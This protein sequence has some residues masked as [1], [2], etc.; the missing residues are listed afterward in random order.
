MKHAYDTENKKILSDPIIQFVE[1]ADKSSVNSTDIF[2]NYTLP[3]AINN[4]VSKGTELKSYSY[5]FFKGGSKNATLEENRKFERLVNFMIDNGKDTLRYYAGKFAENFYKEVYDELSKKGRL[6]TIIV[7]LDPIVIVL[8][9]LLFIPFVLKVQSSLLT[10]YL[11]LCLFKDADINTW[12]EMCNNSIIDIKASIAQIRKIYAD[13][14]FEIKINDNVTNKSK[15]TEKKKPAEKS[16]PNPNLPTGV[17]L[18]V[19]QGL[20][21]NETKNEEEEDSAQLL[22]NNDEAISDRKQKMFSRMTKEKTLSYLVYLI[23]FGLYI[24]AFRIADALVFNSLYNESDMRIYLYQI[25]GDRA[26]QY[27]S[28]LFFSREQLKRNMILKDFERIFTDIRRS[29]SVTDQDASGF[30]VEEAFVTEMKVARIRTDMKGDLLELKKYLN[31]LDTS[32]FC[33]TIF[34]QPVEIQSNICC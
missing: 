4:Y 23:L 21:S 12:L 25:L 17:D 16:T 13:V 26:I 18:T 28:A 2:T 22:K 7:I 15:E 33:E 19:A 24:G 8:L 11:H 6:I 20:Q 5:N 34:N 30:Y 32:Q 14:T 9:M 31:N 10:I 3:F 29:K 27:A 1:K